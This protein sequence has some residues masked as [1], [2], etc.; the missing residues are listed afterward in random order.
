MHCMLGEPL[1]YVLICAIS[2]TVLLFTGLPAKGTTFTWNGKD[3]TTGTNWEDTANWSPVGLPSTNDIAK[4]PNK[5]STYQNPSVNDEQWVL[6]LDLSS[7]GAQNY[8]MDG[9]GTLHI[10]SSGIYGPYGCATW[11]FNIVAD[12]D[13]RWYM[14]GGGWG[15]MEFRALFPGRAAL[16]LLAGRSD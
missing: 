8:T 16:P 13:Q 15:Y 9:K 2:L 12:A 1:A 10:G 3:P 6:G 11:K 7:S 5:G 14:G 4:F